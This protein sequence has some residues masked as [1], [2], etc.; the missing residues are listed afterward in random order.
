MTDKEYI[1]TGGNSAG[2]VV[3]I[4]STVRKPITIATPNVKALLNFLHESG[5]PASLR[6]F[7]IDELDRQVLEFVPGV[8]GNAGTP[9]SLPDLERVGILIRE[10]HEMSARFPI[11]AD[12]T[13]DA[14]TY[15]GD[16][17]LICHNDLAPWNLV[18]NGDR[19][20][21]IDWDNAGPGSRLWDLAYAALT[22]PPVE[23]EGDIAAIASKIRSLTRGYELSE[24][25]CRVLPAMMV[26]R[27]QAM[28][29]HLADGAAKALSPMAQLHAAGHTDYWRGAARFVQEHTLTL[30][31][32]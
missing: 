1:L 25:Q 19:W 22:F 31:E 23:P 28:A 16:V 21:F 11:L 12:A 30:Q 26:K 3:R 9:L 7:G 5:C 17:E 18:R 8:M 14:Q 2:R 20:V 29:D 27:A 4:G 13:W 10:L 6:H 15:P 24:F 32:L